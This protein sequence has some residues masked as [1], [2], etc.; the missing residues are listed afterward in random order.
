MSATLSIVVDS[1]SVAG[2]L[3]FPTFI[4]AEQSSLPIGLLPVSILMLLRIAVNL[5]AL[6]LSSKILHDYTQIGG[7]I[8]IHVFA[9][10]IRLSKMLGD[11]ILISK[12]PLWTAFEGKGFTLGRRPRSSITN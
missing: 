3:A 9:V 5:L 7:G 10:V 1:M 12:A 4:S 2:W 11:Q 6:V 8:F